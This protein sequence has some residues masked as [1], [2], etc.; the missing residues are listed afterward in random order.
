[1][2]QILRPGIQ[3]LLLVLTVFFYSLSLFL[4]YQVLRNAYTLVSISRRKASM[5]HKMEHHLE[6]H[7]PITWP[8]QSFTV[9]HDFKS[10][11]YA[12]MLLDRA[13]S[14]FGLFYHIAPGTG[15][16]AQTPENEPIYFQVSSTRAA[17]SRPG[18]TCKKVCILLQAVQIDLEF[19]T[20][21]HASDFLHSLGRLASKVGNLDFE[22]FEAQS[23]V[24][25]CLSGVSKFSLTM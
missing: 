21:D 17:C 20:A 25:L 2:N 4:I 9:D 18:Q 7:A 15:V 13:N 6:D 23:Y 3:L 11:S 19:T 12:Y 1:M 5:A 16:M 8:I 10:P 22:V 24:V 14:G